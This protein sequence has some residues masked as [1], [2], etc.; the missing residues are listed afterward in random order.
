MLYEFKEDWSDR[1]CTFKE[2]DVINLPV[3]HVLSVLRRVERY[4][5]ELDKLEWRGYRIP[6]HIL[7][8]YQKRA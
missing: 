6:L 1:D 4:G 7:K 8:P 5:K 3:V 2:G